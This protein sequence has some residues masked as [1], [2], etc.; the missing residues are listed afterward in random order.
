LGGICKNRESL[1]G[2]SEV[3]PKKKSTH[4]V[5]KLKMLLRVKKFKNSQ[6][7][8]LQKLKNEAFVKSIF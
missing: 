6:N 1:E 2:I 8:L 5:K 3:S 7:A 4:L